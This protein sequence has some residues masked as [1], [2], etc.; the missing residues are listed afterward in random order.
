MA[1]GLYA[2][3]KSKA[4]TVCMK[5]KPAIPGPVGQATSYRVVLKTAEGWLGVDHPFDLAQFMDSAGEGDGGPEF[6]KPTEEAEP[7]GLEG[8][9]EFIEE[10]PPE[11]L[12]ED[13]DGQEE[14][15]AAGEP[16]PPVE[17]GTAAG[18][19]TMNVGMMVQVLAPGM[20]N[21]NEADLGTEMP[22]LG[23]DPAQGLGRRAQQ[24][25]IDYGLV[26]ERHLGHRRRHGEDDME[27]GYRQQFGLAL[28]QPFGTGI[29]LALGA[30]P[31][32]AGN[33]RCPLPVL[34]ANS[35]MES[36][37]RG[38]GSIWRAARV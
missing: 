34:W 7:A 23:R 22:G 4:R 20:Q 25:G 35:V 31:V 14:P 6:G 17:R 2:I 33:G 12:R 13:T 19:D 24:D 38:E 11:E 21:G 18:H 36:R 10:Q 27:I 3:G 15:R 29:A 9:A 26:L 32:A 8:G 16:L 1:G 30:V 28:R 37:P 5:A